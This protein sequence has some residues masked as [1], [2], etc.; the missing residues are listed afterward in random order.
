MNDSTPTASELLNA[1][2]KILSVSLARNNLA[3]LKKYEPDENEKIAQ[4]EYAVEVLL[5]AMRQCRTLDRYDDATS[6]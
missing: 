3:L 5:R 4:A 1:C 6:A 2:V